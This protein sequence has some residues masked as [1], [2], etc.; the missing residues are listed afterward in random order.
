MNKCRPISLSLPMYAQATQMLIYNSTCSFFVE[1]FFV[2]TFLPPKAFLKLHNVPNVINSS[3]MLTSKR[4]VVSKLGRALCESREFILGRTRSHVCCCCCCHHSRVVYVLAVCCWN[5]T[6]CGD[7]RQLPISL[8]LGGWVIPF[9]FFF[10][11]VCYIAMMQLLSV[12]EMRN[13][14]TH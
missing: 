12:C 1:C 4:V 13:T 14:Y 7:W 8:L 6:C 10:P 2:F 11:Y 5:Y 9:F 3:K